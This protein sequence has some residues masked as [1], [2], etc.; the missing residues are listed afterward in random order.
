MTWAALLRE[1]Q[2]MRHYLVML[3]L[4]IPFGIRAQTEIYKPYQNTDMWSADTLYMGASFIYTP[5]GTSKPVVVTLKG[6]EAGWT[7]ELY[8]INPNAAKPPIYLFTNHNAPGTSVDVT[9]YLSKTLPTQL[10]FMYKVV[11]DG[12]PGGWTLYPED[13]L[14]KYTGPNRS[15]DQYF[16]QA[17]SDAMPNPN[18]RFGHRWSV[19]GKVPGGSGDLE[20]GFEDCTTAIS[21]MD[22]DDVV[23]GVTGLQIGVFT[24]FLVTKDFVR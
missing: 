12:G 20:F 3:A 23:F 11:D 8:L 2:Y 17:S 24:R 16:S 7:G 5:S 21:D 1:E 15:K 18:W 4:A 14:P 13:M 10:T 22:F 19:V 6:N 9:G